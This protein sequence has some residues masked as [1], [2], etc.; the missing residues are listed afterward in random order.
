MQSYYTCKHMNF[1]I[2]LYTFIYTYIHISGVKKVEKWNF[3]GASLDQGL[4]FNT[5]A[6]S[7]VQYDT[8]VIILDDIKGQR[9]S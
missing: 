6:V 5:Y 2:Y 3:N 1:S 7:N 4:L 8:S 9:V